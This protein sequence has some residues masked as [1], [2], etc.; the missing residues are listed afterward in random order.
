MGR[1]LVVLGSTP[2]FEEVADEEGSKTPSARSPRGLC[3][4]GS[5]AGRALE[6][7]AKRFESCM[8][9]ASWVQARGGD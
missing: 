6:K 3:C 5:S 7:A 2:A 9:R 1:R 4:P 8:G